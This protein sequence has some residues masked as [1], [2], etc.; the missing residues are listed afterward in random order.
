MVLAIDS[1]QLKTC[2]KCLQEKTVSE[3]HKLNKNGLFFRYYSYCKPCSSKV[4]LIYAKRNPLA[5]KKLQI[6]QR[7]SNPSHSS[8]KN[9]GGKGVKNYLTEEDLKRL[10]KR[11]KGHL[12]KH[13]SIDRIDS[14]GDYSY[15]N[16]RFIE[17]KENVLRKRK[18]SFDKI[19][20][21]RLDYSKGLKTQTD[22]AKEYGTD[23]THVSM[24]VRNK[25]YKDA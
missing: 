22:L 4:S 2:R 23:Q 13:P 20:K 7:C 21:L 3:F 19:R 25:Y 9:Y 11:D 12:L 8:F 14:D 17:L 18:F 10:W 5:I 1:T 15:E 16:C 24:I 6:D